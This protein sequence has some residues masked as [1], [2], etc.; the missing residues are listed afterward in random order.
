[1]AYKVKSTTKFRRGLK[2]CMKRGWK[3]EKLNAVIDYLAE[4]GVA[5]A[6]PGPHPLKGIY[7]GYMECHIE[8]D[9][10]LL[11]EKHDKELILLLLDTGTHSELLKK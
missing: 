6:E 11:W 1:M 3:M 5:P 9:W 10:L 4:H 7:K 2:R 8:P